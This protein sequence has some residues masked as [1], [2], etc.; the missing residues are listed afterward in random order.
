MKK[1]D[2]IN[3]IQIS[4]TAIMKKNQSPCAQDPLI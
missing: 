1:I 2:I 3:D 4:D